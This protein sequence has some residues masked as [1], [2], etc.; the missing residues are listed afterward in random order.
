VSPSAARRLLHAATGLLLLLVPLTSWGVL[1]AAL[2][3]AA[4]LAAGAEIA[5]LRSKRFGAL[6]ARAVPV[7][8]ARETSRPSGAM[9]LAVGYALA[10]LVPPPAPAAGLLV[11][12]LADPAAAWAGSAWGR[13]NGKTLA[14]SA[15]HLVVAAAVLYG[16]GCSVTAVAVGATLATALERW[17]L[18]LDD[19]LLVAPVTALTAAL[20]G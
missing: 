11:G 16:V 1:R 14:G 6:L 10:S 3:A 15:V 17:P 5:R 13:G 4:I 9:W 7:F 20:L 8:R 18:G 19:N 12:A 2:V